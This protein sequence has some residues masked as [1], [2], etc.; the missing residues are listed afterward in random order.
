M[1]AGTDN[2]VKQATARTNNRRSFDSAAHD[3]T[4]SGFAQDDGKN[5]QRRKQAK[6]KYRDSGCARMTASD[7]AP[8]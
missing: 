5:K 2:D 8:E 3:E 4:V 1:T 7:A 6:T